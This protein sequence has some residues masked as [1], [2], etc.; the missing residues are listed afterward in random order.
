M[1]ANRKYVQKQI[2]FVNRVFFK[3]T[4]VAYDGSGAVLIE[5]EGGA[6][7]T[8]YRTWLGNC[9]LGCNL[10][11]AIAEDHDLPFPVMQEEI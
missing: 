4:K 8:P 3:V 11:R 9:Q 7:T 6:R 2:D 1:L 10:A 5:G